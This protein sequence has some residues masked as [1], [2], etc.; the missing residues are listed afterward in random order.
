VFS[1]YFVAR[2]AFWREWLAVNEALF[3][4]CE[5]PE[6]PLREQLLQPTSYDGVAQ[7]K[8]FVME[9][10]A[11]FLLATQPQWRT[12]AADPYGYVWSMT[13]LREHPTEAFISDALKIAFR[14]QGFP[15]YMRAYNHIRR[16]VASRTP[17]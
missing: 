3:A 10:V 2:P 8:V 16:Q 6:T 12:R 17:A 7:R 13:R 1:N 15:E 11:P 4:L 9:R 14:E 5:G